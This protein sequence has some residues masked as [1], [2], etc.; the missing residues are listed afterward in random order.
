MNLA[1][2]GSHSSQHIS[3][4]EVQQA[5]LSENTA[6]CCSGS[7]GS[8]SACWEAMIAQCTWS[9][10]FP[11]RI[12]RCCSPLPPSLWVFTFA[13][14]KCIGQVS[15]KKQTRRLSISTETD[16]I[17]TF[18]LSVCLSSIERN[19]LR[20]IDFWGTDFHDDEDSEVS[21]S[22]VCMLEPQENQWY[23]LVQV[24]VTENQGSWW[25]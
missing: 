15:P 11:F 23:N 10:Y 6:Q 12:R 7:P 1:N 16:I 21:R 8:S 18:Y 20:W 5:A 9:F 3:G 22:L 13:L 2:W 14:P 24:Q 19:P 17:S 4:W 25:Y